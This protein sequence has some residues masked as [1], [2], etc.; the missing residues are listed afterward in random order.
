MSYKSILVTITGPSLVGK[1]TLAQLLKEHQFY[2]LV[3]TTTRP[4]RTGEING[5]HYDFIT[6]N[7]FEQMDKNGEMIESVKVSNNYYGLSKKSL[8]LVMLTGANAA[9]VIEPKGAHQVQTFCEN[10]NIPLFKVF[11]NNPKEVLFKRFL[12]RYKNDDMAI[13]QVYVD[14]LINMTT[15]E[16]DDWINPAYNKTEHYDLIIDSFDGENTNDVIN[17]ITQAANS[18]VKKNIIKKR[19]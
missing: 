15:K 1:S 11:L 6:N 8:D 5:V 17:Q 4:Q 16:I 19:I 3:S 18:V 7:E 9:V 14:R 2:E 13:D 10:N 12:E